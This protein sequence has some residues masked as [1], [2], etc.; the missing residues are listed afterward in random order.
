MSCIK[1]DWL[2]DI[3]LPLFNLGLV[4]VQLSIWVY[5]FC[6]W[7]HLCCCYRSTWLLMTSQVSL[8]SSQTCCRQW[9]RCWQMTLPVWWPWCLGKPQ[10]LKLKVWTLGN[11]FMVFFILVLSE[12]FVLFS[13]FLYAL[14]SELFLSFIKLFYT[15][16]PQYFDCML[17]VIPLFFAFFN[18][19]S[20]KQYLRFLHQYGWGFRSSW[21]WCCVI[22]WVAL[23]FSSEC[24]AFIQHQAVKEVCSTLKKKATRSFEVLGATHP[25]TLHHTLEDFSSHLL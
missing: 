25:M 17:C 20:S 22:G 16:L 2:F 9:T 11:S 14:T 19:S 6:R 23:N 5:V 24:V 7:M 1:K 18:I 3:L 10:T 13:Y 21:I 8:L 12:C 15:I 4:S